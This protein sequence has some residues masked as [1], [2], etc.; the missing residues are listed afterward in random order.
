MVHRGLQARPPFSRPLAQRILGERRREGWCSCRRVAAL[1]GAQGVVGANQGHRGVHAARR[2]PHHLF[3]FLCHGVGTSPFAEASDACIRLE[4][5]P[6]ARRK[7]APAEQQVHTWRHSRM[8]DAEVLVD[9]AI[10]GWQHEHYVPS[11]TRSRRG[12]GVRC[13]FQCVEDIGAVPVWRR[14]DHDDVGSMSQAG[15]DSRHAGPIRSAQAHRVLDEL[16]VI[17][18]RT[19]LRW[20]R[21]GAWLL[22]PP[23][24]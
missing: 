3:P 1:A 21:V 20:R 18:G 8:A 9:L 22:L 7:T 24:R 6:N 19:T 11:P 14:S 5:P 17:H 10:V 15:G 23:W 2:A 16:E 4:H 13:R 12:V